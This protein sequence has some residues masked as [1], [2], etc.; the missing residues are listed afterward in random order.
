MVLL[1]SGEDP[2]FGLYSNNVRRA[3]RQII[4][5][6][7]GETGFY[8]GKNGGHSSMYNHGFAMLALAEAYGAVDDRNLWTGNEPNRRTVGQ[9]LE[10]AVRA[11]ITSQ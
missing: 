7:D 8:G 4:E 1:A 5:G 10:L 6:Q 3:L 11:A 9:S 2:N